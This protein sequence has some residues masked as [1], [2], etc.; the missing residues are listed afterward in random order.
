M[1]FYGTHR[2]LQF[3]RRLPPII[4][5]VREIKPRLGE[6]V[7]FFLVGQ[8]GEDVLRH[9]L[10]VAA[11]E[12][13]LVGFRTQRGVGQGRGDGGQAHRHGLQQFVLQARTNAHRGDEDATLRVGVADVVQPAADDDLYLLWHKKKS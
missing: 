6:A 2:L 4:N 10:G 7:G 1:V 12:D 3:L 9:F 5:T 11:D 8:E 13:F